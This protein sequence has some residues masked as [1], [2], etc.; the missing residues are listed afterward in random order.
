MRL[1]NDFGSSSDQLRELIHTDIDH[2]I[3]RYYCD[4]GGT[5][6]NTVHANVLA[7]T[8]EVARPKHYQDLGRS[9]LT[10]PGIVVIGA[11]FSYDSYSPLLDE[12]EGI[13]CAALETLAVPT[14]TR[15]IGVMS[16]RFGVF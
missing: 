6:G 13:A 12:M 4:G 8:L 5:A 10:T 7:E 9:I 1:L 3:L 15:C 16:R 14:S 2:E 11:G